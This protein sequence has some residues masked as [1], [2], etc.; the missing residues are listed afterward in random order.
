MVPLDVAR[1]PRHA[2]L[3]MDAAQP[4]T[5]TVALM[6]A[7]QPPTLFAALP[8]AVPVVHIAVAR[9]A[10]PVILFRAD[11]PDILNQEKEKSLIVCSTILKPLM[12]MQRHVKLWHT[13]EK[14]IGCI[15]SS[16]LHLVV[17][18]IRMNVRN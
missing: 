7:A 4:P 18:A 9:N 14:L 13:I 10:V 1:M 5:R 2:A 12:F 3:V 11:C 17:L 8:A 16:K 6:D 15:I